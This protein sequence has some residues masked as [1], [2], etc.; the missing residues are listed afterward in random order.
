MAASEIPM[1][2]VECAR[3]GCKTVV[4]VPQTVPHGL[5]EQHF[6]EVWR[7]FWVTVPGGPPVVPWVSGA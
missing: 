3:E 2:T 5:C 7:A 4:T 6:T 1:V